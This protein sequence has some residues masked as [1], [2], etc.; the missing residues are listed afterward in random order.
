VTYKFKAGDTVKGIDPYSRTLYIIEPPNHN[1]VNDYIVR[2]DWGQGRYPFPKL[3]DR[4]QLI[5]N[6]V[7]IMLECL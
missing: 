1:H 2:D 4:Y 7:R 3:E 5:N 6:G